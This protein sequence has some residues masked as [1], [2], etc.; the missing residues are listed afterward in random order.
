M[1]KKT[2]KLMTK[3]SGQGVVID[4]KPKNPE[5][6]SSAG[7]V[8]QE[9]MNV[10]LEKLQS[11]VAELGD[12]KDVA[13]R[14]T[15]DFYILENRME[16]FSTK[17]YWFVGTLITIVFGTFLIISLDYFKWSGERYEKF[18]DKTQ[19]IRNGYYS[20]EEIDKKISE[21]KS[22]ALSNGLNRCLR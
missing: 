7:S 19:E 12:L 13:A 6:S 4:Q 17:M 14:V 15:K 10:R 11:E 21:F 2:E 8:S 1:K 22:C 5:A 16:K 20:K 18:V 3:V 9:S